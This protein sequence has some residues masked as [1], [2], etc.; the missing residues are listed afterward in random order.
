MNDSPNSTNSPLSSLTPQELANKLEKLI[1]YVR[2]SAKSDNPEDKWAKASIQNHTDMQRIF[3]DY[4]DD[5]ITLS[6]TRMK[7]LCPELYEQLIYPA[8]EMAEKYGKIYKTPPPPSHIALEKHYDNFNFNNSEYFDLMIGIKMLK[9]QPNMQ[10]AIAVTAHE[11]GHIYQDLASSL[12]YGILFVGEIDKKNLRPEE[13]DKR[14]APMDELNPHYQEL[15]AD[16]FV[17][18]IIN[19][20]SRITQIIDYQKHNNNDDNKHKKIFPNLRKLIK[21]SVERALSNEIYGMNG[22]WETKDGGYHFVPTSFSE[23][24]KIITDKVIKNIGITNKIDLFF[25]RKFPVTEEGELVKN[26]EQLKIATEKKAEELIKQLD[27]LAESGINTEKK[28]QWMNN[29]LK[30]I[31]EFKETN[32]PEFLNKQDIPERTWRERI[33]EL[34][35]QVFKRGG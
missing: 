11:W 9:K 27:K 14:F 7:E 16:R 28:Q 12:N 33:G 13:E 22:E 18:P 1:D 26:A 25:L 8:I 31:T 23:S 4:T 19:I 30:E 17:E 2:E 29:L 6:Y 24:P 15:S 35:T 3:T 10:E 20:A 21:A 5:G 34:G 32:K